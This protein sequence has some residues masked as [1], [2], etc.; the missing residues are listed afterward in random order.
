[1]CK[2]L[3]LCTGEGPRTAAS[4]RARTFQCKDAHVYRH[5]IYKNQ[6]L[7]SEDVTIQF[8]KES[9]TNPSQQVTC[10]ANHPYQ[11]STY[12]QLASRRQGR[13]LKILILE[14]SEYQNQRIWKDAYRRKY[15]PSYQILKILNMGSISS[16][17]HEMEI[18]DFSGQFPHIIFFR[19]SLFCRTRY[20]A[21]TR[22]PLMRSLFPDH[23]YMWCFGVRKTAYFHIQ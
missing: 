3:G 10:S 18:L 9:N 21:S 23:F 22:A 19:S 13:S 7:Y 4:G 12:Q 6:F 11:Q 2:Q 20:L 16:K 1:M 17:K 14:I 15:D 8:L 5:T